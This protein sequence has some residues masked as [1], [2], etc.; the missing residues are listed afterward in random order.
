MWPSWSVCL[1]GSLTKPGS[2]VIWQIDNDDDVQVRYRLF[3]LLELQLE[4]G[5]YSWNMVGHYIAVTGVHR[6]PA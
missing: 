1:T 2:F 3:C 6:S 4:H 5:S